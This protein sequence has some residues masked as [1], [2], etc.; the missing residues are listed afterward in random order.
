[1]YSTCRGSWDEKER[2]RFYWW[3]I[4]LP[5]GWN[6]TGNLFFARKTWE[7]YIFQYFFLHFSFFENKFLIYLEPVELEFVF[8]GGFCP[9]GTENR[10]ALLVVRPKETKSENIIAKASIK[11]N[12]ND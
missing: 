3:R 9:A 12:L 8:A 7:I 4:T 6:G 5:L 10:G 1:M 11:V 2:M